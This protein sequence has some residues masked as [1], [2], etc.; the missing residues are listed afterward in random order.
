MAFAPQPYESD[1]ETTD[2]ECLQCGSELDADAKWCPECDSDALEYHH[3][4]DHP[5]GFEDDDEYYIAKGPWGPARWVYA[6]KE[7][8]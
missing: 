1:L 5:L 3:T 2:A 6:G 8:T 4:S 7:P